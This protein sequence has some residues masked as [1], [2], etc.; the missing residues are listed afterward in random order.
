VCYCSVIKCV[1]FAISSIGR[2]NPELYALSAGTWD[3]QKM[4]IKACALWNDLEAWRRRY[5]EALCVNSWQV[6]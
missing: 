2:V 3:N 5:A 1:Y 6:I 4:D